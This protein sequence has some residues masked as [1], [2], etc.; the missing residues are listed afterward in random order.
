MTFGFLVG[1]QN[2]CKLFC[3]SWEVFVLHGYDCI[4]CVAKSSTTTAYRWLFRDS[5]PSL[6][7]LW[8]AVIKSPNF[9]LWARLH[10]CVFCKKPFAISVLKQMS[11][12]RSFGKWVKMLCLLCTTFAR[13]SEGNSWAELEASRCSGTLSS[14]RLSLNEFPRTCSLSSI[15]FS[16]SVSAGPCDE[17]PRTSSIKLSLLVDAGCSV[18]VTVSCYED[19]GEVGEDWAWRACR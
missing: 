4:H 12:F 8:S 6:R 1:S 5:H 2:L 17:F 9:P 14:T 3:V 19:V 10:W 13:H 15:L 16:F 11:Q 7:T 18:G